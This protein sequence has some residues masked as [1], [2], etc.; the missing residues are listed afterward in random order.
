MLFGTLAP[1]I[2]HGE[3]ELAPDPNKSWRYNGGFS[4]G[5]IG[6]PLKGHH[7][8][9]YLLGYRNGTALYWFNRGDTEGY[10]NLHPTSKNPDYLQGWQQGNATRAD[11]RFDKNFEPFPTHTDDNYKNYYIG[12][13]DGAVAADND[14]NADGTS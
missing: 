8:Q 4:Q 14:N 6:L 7:T 1:A 10:Y 12:V 11:V 13:H 9:E 2:A 3:N 5:Y